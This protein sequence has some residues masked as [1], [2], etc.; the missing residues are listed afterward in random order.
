MRLFNSSLEGNVRRAI[1][2]VE[3]ARVDEEA[4]RALVQAAV[5]LN[6]AKASRTSKRAA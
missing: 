5:S 1:D 2:Y 4:L 3:G 6:S